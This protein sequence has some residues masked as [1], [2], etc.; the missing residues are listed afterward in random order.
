M[1]KIKYLFYGCQSFKKKILISGKNDELFLLNVLT[2]KIISKYSND[3]DGKVYFLNDKNFIAAS[4]LKWGFNLYD[5]NNS[6]SIIN[7][8]NK[9]IACYKNYY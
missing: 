6:K 4:I 5:I 7:E 1:K 9:I 3:V 2:L 8:V